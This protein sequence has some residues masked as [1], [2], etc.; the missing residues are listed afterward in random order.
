MN[1]LMGETGSFV[2]N[3]RVYWKP[4]KFRKIII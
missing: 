1:Y 3:A 2:L 4:M